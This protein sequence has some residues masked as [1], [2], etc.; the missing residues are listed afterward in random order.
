MPI[1]DWKRVDAGIFHDFHH[2]WI[3]AIKRSL[4]QGLLSPAFYA[5]AEQITGNM[6]LNVLTLARQVSGPLEVAEVLSGSGLAVA[7]APPRVRFLRWIPPRRSVS[8][9]GGLRRRATHDA[10]VSEP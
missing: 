3:A 7:T 4:N 9:A 5:L 1:H 6:I 10:G 2:S 8:R